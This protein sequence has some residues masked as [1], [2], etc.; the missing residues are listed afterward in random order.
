MVEPTVCFPVD[1]AEPVTDNIPTAAL[2]LILPL[3]LSFPLAAVTAAVMGRVVIRVPVLLPPLLLLPGRRLVDDDETA[4]GVPL[5]AVEDDNARGL[6]LLTLPLPLPVLPLA[7]SDETNS[8]DGTRVATVAVGV[9]VFV[10][11]DDDAVD[12]RDR[13]RD[14][15]L[16][17]R[18]RVA[19]EEDELGGAPPPWL[20][21]LPRRNDDADVM[22]D[23]RVTNGAS[24]SSSWFSLSP[25]ASSPR[26]A[27]ATARVLSAPRL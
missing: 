17:G 9:A 16:V 27:T 12:A 11:D 22:E 20:P 13:V 26:A 8:S 19:A 7:S 1:T 3:L 25:T 21:L 18:G 24:S 15:A 5:F 14:D 4:P 10:A 2:P 23:A 6:P